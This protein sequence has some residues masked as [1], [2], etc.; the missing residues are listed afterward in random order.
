MPSAQTL[1]AFI[2]L[3]EANQH[4]A[5][6]ERFYT[7]DASMQENMTPPRV[8][9]DVL[10]KAEAAVMAA[11]RSVRSTCVRPVFVEGDTV[12][13]RWIFDFVRQDGHSF[14]LEELAYQRWR[15]ELVAQEQFF[16]DPAQMKKAV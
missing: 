3:V 4:V 12:V 13:I 7:E 10:V 15:G 2:A 5:A 16:Y 9:R 1:E 14:R 11:T 8:G 6:I